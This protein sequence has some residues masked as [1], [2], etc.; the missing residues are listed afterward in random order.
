MGLAMVAMAQTPTTFPRSYHFLNCI[1]VTCGTNS[2]YGVTNQLSYSGAFT[3]IAGVFMTNNAGTAV[4]IGAGTNDVLNLLKD[5]PLWSLRNG[6]PLV[7]WPTNNQQA[8]YLNKSIGFGRFQFRVVGTNAAAT[9][10]VHFRFTP[11]WD[12]TNESTLATDV[13]DVPIVANG[14][15]IATLTTNAPF[16]LWVGA[17][18]LRLKEIYNTS[19]S[20]QGQTWVLDV[21]LNG[22]AP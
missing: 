16:Y 10:T 19:A 18:K 4:I 21:T 1:A 22:F 5:I 11:L 6:E 13:W 17:Q 7:Y 15:T 20:N 8:E 14:T 12:G 3:N 9:G 2:T